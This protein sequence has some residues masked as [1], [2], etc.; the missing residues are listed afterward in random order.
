MMTGGDDMKYGQM[1]EE[2]K[3][4][5]REGGWVRGKEEEKE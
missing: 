2:E 4:G 5:A 1:K 3:E